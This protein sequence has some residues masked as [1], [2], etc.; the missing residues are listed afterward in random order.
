MILWPAAR[1][2]SV[3]R[4][5]CLVGVLLASVLPPAHA[6][7][8]A[9][10]GSGSDFAEL[11]IDQWRPDVAREGFSINYG[12]GASGTGRAQFS[13]GLVDF[14]GTDTPYLTEDPV[15]KP[16]QPFLYVNTSAGGLGFMYHLTD[17]Q[18]NPITHLNLTPEQV[19]GMFLYGAG[20]TSVG[21]AA[22]DLYWDTFAGIQA[23][24][25]NASLPH[26]KILK[27]ARSDPGGI[28]Y[29][30]MEFCIAD[31]PAAWRFSQDW[32]A[33]YAPSAAPCSTNRDPYQ[34]DGRPH[35]LW[36]SCAFPGILDT[37][38]DATAND[39]ASPNGEGAITYVETSFAVVRGFPVASV[40]NSAGV[41]TQPTAGN[42][43]EALAFATTA[44][45]GTLRLA[46]NAPRPD[47]YFP[48]TYSY[49]VV[50][51]A[52]IDP[53]KGAVLAHFLN[54]A[55]T[56]G[57]LNAS[58]LGFAPL[59]CGIV[60][61]SLDDIARIPGAP[62]RPGYRCTA[63]DP[64]TVPVAAP[65]PPG[66]GSGAAA[67]T[68]GG[69]TAGPSGPAGTT[70]PTAAGGSPVASPRVLPA[71][72]ASRPA[73]GEGTRPDGQPPGPPPA[74]QVAA[75]A[76]T[77]E[78]SPAQE[79]PA[80]SPLSVGDAVPPS[81]ARLVLAILEGAALFLLAAGMAA[82]ARRGRLRR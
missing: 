26:E 25:P 36:A 78:A 40:R 68:V 53:A 71:A 66:G 45:D 50:P 13:Q 15:P 14:A 67:T 18:G 64:A 2:S 75:G 46:F 43:N 57:Q 9:V 21:G 19:C 31:A 7:G 41:Y 3:A 76:P 22:K 1:L 56:D 77:P 61:G 72:G 35:D 73:I 12:A 42:V 29:I 33:A 74:P 65:S 63:P 20:A 23:A 27:Y 69:S 11:E 32:L 37:Y 5:L 82:L 30:F 44:G 81:P 17:T 62:P 39:V 70:R 48:S 79:A 59:A 10:N 80:A 28:N 4:T 8:P 52:N 38:S 6:A 24:N 16:S 34:L 60:N 55:V 54:H 51:T 58:V 49:M 47:V